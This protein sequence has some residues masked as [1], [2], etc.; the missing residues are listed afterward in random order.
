MNHLKLFLATFL[1]LSGSVSA[2]STPSPK[3]DINANTD[4][5]RNFIQKIGTTTA[6][7]IGIL[8]STAPFLTSQ[9][10]A[11][12]EILNT[13]S[14]V[15]YAVTQ[16]VSKG[17]APQPGDIVAIEYT[18][19]LSNGQIFDA[20]HSIGKK[21][22][23]LFKLGS[24]VVI[25][26]LNDVVNQMQVGEKVQAIIPPGLAFGDEG[27]CLESGECLIKPGSTLVYDVFLKKTS[28]PPP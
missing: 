22:A 7:T 17:L 2:F 8:S 23:L 24:T 5:R 11:A 19:Y 10:N 1:C 16:P 14:G 3:I 26:G 9:A 25:P 4:S 12:P 6:A 27:I 21:N 20:T 18:G 15:K 28:I 13:P